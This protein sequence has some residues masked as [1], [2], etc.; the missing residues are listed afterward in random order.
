MNL[1]RSI[2]NRFSSTEG[3]FFKNVAWLFAGSAAAQVLTLAVSP[4]L[5]RLYSPDA[6]GSLGVF[7]SIA[8]VLIIFAALRYEQAIP[9]AD[10]DDD[11]WHLSQLAAVV[12]LTFSLSVFAVLFFLSEYTELFAAENRWLFVCL[13]PV[14]TFGGSLYRIALNASIRAKLYSSIASTKVRQAIGQVCVQVGMGVLYPVPAGLISGFIVGQVGGVLHLLKSLGRA[15]KLGSHS[16]LS[17]L[18]NRAKKFKEFPLI[19]SWAILFNSLSIHMPGLLV[20]KFFGLEAAGFYFLSRRVISAPLIMIRNAISQVYLGEASGLYRSD[21]LRFRRLF[22]VTSR[23]LALAGFLICGVVALLAPFL[24]PLAFGANWGGAGQF[25][26]ILA[27]HQMF[28]FVVG[29]MA[30]TTI[31]VGKRKAQLLI[32]ILRFAS[33]ALSFY[34]PSRYGFDVTAVLMSYVAV[35]GLYYLMNYL[36]LVVLVLRAEPTKVHS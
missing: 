17:Q 16:T 25:A 12:A 26:Q 6:F 15:G 5:S 8:S 19:L 29:P 30:Q 18:G 34:I 31:I 33:V 22:F 9:L 28:Q 14:V 24:V 2:R 20:A 27:I 13:L 21:R 32:D 11:A 35:S 4:I 7:T 1:I 10:E 36:Y 3:A 23:N